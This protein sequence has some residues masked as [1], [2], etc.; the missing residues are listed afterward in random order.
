MLPWLMA[1]FR[2]KTYWPSPV[3]AV[4]QKRPYGGPQRTQILG[5]EGD[6]NGED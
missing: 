3:N 5:N 1:S 4:S 2:V 6:Q